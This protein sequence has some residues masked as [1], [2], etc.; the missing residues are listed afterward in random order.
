MT[1]KVDSTYSQIN[2]GDTNVKTPAPTSVAPFA[3]GDDSSGVIMGYL[4][5]QNHSYHLVQAKNRTW[6]ATIDHWT[7][8]GH[9]A[10]KAQWD[11]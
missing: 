9:H 2:L 10:W 11:L 3:R 5:H 4:E 7:R 8:K 6:R 1:I